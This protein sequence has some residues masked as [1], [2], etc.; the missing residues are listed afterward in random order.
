M[1]TDKLKHLDHLEDFPIRHG[2]QGFNS[3]ISTLMK[4][5]D[6]LNGKKPDN[7]NITQ[8]WDGSPSTVFGHIPETDKFFISTKSAFNKTPK[9]SY[10]LEDIEK[11]YKHAPGLV[12]KLQQAFVALQDQVPKKGVFQGDMMYTPEDLEQR[13]DKI[14][15]QPNTLK[16]TADANSP[17]GRA[18]KGSQLGIVVHTEY[19]GDSLQ[20]MKATFNVD[21]SK[22]KSGPVNFISPQVEAKAHY[23]PDDEKEFA[24]NL[25]K[26]RELNKNMIK[27]NSYES[28]QGHEPLLFNYINRSVRLDKPLSVSNYIS[29]IKLRYEQHVKEAKQ[30][31]TRLKRQEVE[32]TLI[33]HIME[34]KKGL[35]DVFGL[36]KH[37]Q[38]AKDVLVNA[39]AKAPGGFKTSIAGKP[40]KGEGYVATNNGV[41]TKLVDRKEFSAA[42]FAK[43]DT[44]KDSAK[45]PMDSMVFSFGRMNPP[46]IGHEKLVDKVKSIAKEM[47]IGH[48]IVLSASQDP[49]KNPLSPEQKLAYAKTAFPDTNVEVADAKAHNI[50]DQ[51]KKLHKQGVRHLTV[52]TGSDRTDEFSKVIN[53]YNGKPGMFNFKRINFISA[54][55]RDPNAKGTE[56]MS[57]SKAREAVKMNDYKTFRAGMPKHIDDKTATNMFKDLRIKMNIGAENPPKIDS[58]TPGIALARF[59]KNKTVGGQAKSEI[60]RRKRAGIWRGK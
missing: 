39:M 18:I 43:N 22:F 7:F 16:Y 4:T 55:K 53:K 3:I 41:P 26:A 51:L 29:F 36:H 5:H 13:G 57:A 58:K 35:E 44:S 6:F 34:N 15:F 14:S 28:I 27:S 60:E 42:N 8:K 50:M 30:D 10:N 40:T 17:E 56:G 20:N 59:L 12:K 1:E 32:N 25:M 33:K 11:N 21:Q 19:K 31:K 23:T 52:V 45:N 47:G 2:Q 54:G 9:I 46:T 37:L 48:K 49:I 24:L 38:A